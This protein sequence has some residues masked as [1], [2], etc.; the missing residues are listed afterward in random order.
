VPRSWRRTVDRLTAFVATFVAAVELV[1]IVAALSGTTGD[2]RPVLAI[3]ALAQLGL[4]GALLATRLPTLARAP[5]A[6]GAATVVLVLTA[7]IGAGGGV[8][9]FAEQLLPVNGL[10]AILVAVVAVGLPVRHGAALVAASGPAYVA[11]RAWRVDEAWLDSVDAWVL[12]AGPTAAI[13]VVLGHLRR[14]ATEADRLAQAELD[15]A[16][17]RQAAVQ[18]AHAVDDA[19]R[20]L[21]DD[22]ISALYAVEVGLDVERVD[23]ACASALASIGSAARVTTVD[24]LV[25]RLREA[26]PLELDVRAGDWVAPPPP[27]VLTALRGA[28]AEALRNAHR[29]GGATTATVELAAHETNARVRIVDDGAGLPVDHAAGFGIGQSIEGRMH[30]VGGSGAVAPGATGGVEVDLVW[31]HRPPEPDLVAGPVV[32]DRRWVTRPL[33]G[34]TIAIT[35]YLAVRN[36]GDHPLLSLAAAIGVAALALVACR[37]AEGR[38]PGTAAT[39][40]F[41]LAGIA[42]TALGIVAAGPGALLSERSWVI[43]SV[44]NTVAVLG[45][46]ARATWTALVIVGQVAVVLVAAALEPGMAVTAPVGSVVT[47][48]VVGGFGLLLGVG[49]RRDEAR[50]ADARAALVAGVG[51]GEDDE[52]WAEGQSAAR[53]VHLAH[54]EADVVP[55]LAGGRHDSAV[56][57]DDA[58][59][60]AA[61]CRDDLVLTVP[62]DPETRTALGGARRRGVT[63]AIRVPAPEHAFVPATWPLLRAVVDAA[64]AGHRVTVVPPGGAAPGRVVVVPALA[65]PGLV[66]EPGGPASTYVVGPASPEATTPEPT[67][68]RGRVAG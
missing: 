13:L 37:V 47:P 57:E 14:G 30:D 12:A 50:L 3:V 60:L 17:S 62:L 67:V 41:G 49:L 33:A 4:V 1:A 24:E 53:R 68:A 42:I 18:A 59:L 6:I 36:P 31:P 21:H 65:V 16:R 56:P 23:R 22:V 51:D 27:R 43:G 11:L 10:Q 32:G 58:R 7:G 34:L 9:E 45:F 29:H 19:R 20:V 2:A 44:A 66:A 40:G 55:F 46:Q 35:A 28:A 54:L 15:L 64:A 39:L 38:R 61:R 8:P 52:A 26:A 25:A 48:V 63:V 5:L